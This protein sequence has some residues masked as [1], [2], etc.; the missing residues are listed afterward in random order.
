MLGVDEV[1]RFG[2]F[3]ASIA[4]VSSY[5]VLAHAADLIFQDSAVAPEFAAPLGKWDGPFIGVFGGVARGN[6]TSPVDFDLRGAL[7]GVN[8]GANFTLDNGIVL[9]V[10]GD[11]AWSNITD[12]EVFL[13]PSAFDVNWFGSVRGRVGYD[14]GAFMPYLTAGVA[15]A[16][17]RLTAFTGDVVASQVHLGWTI[18]AGVEVKATDNLSIDLAYRYSDY[19]AKSYGV[20]SWDFANHQVTGGLNWHF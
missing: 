12:D 17:A 14:A 3:F 7:L 6:A 15:A 19:G 16:G 10:V 9:G 4:A 18:G 8:A 13:P 11:V 5:S 1:K 20:T 2:L